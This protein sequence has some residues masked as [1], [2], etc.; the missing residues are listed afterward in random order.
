MKM[1]GLSQHDR[2][3]P[4]VKKEMVLQAN[5]RNTLNT[6]RVFNKLN[7][8]SKGILSSDLLVSF[9]FRILLW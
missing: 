1:N 7:I 5:N 3:M 6:Q 9:T 4:Q 8:R 2:S